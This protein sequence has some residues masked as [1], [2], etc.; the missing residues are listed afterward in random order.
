MV[1]EGLTDKL[2]GCRVAVNVNHNPKGSARIDARQKDALILSVDVEHDVAAG[3]EMERE[4]DAGLDVALGQSLAP[5][6]W[7][8]RQICFRN[9]QNVNKNLPECDRN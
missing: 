9:T 2:D 1:S 6:S 3:R 8:A 5:K 7:T 4:Q